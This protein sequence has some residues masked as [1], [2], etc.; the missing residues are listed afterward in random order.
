MSKKVICVLTIIAAL[1][2][3]IGNAK[4]TSKCEITLIEQNRYTIECDEKTE[5]LKLK[6][7]DLIKIKKL[8]KRKVGCDS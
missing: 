2:P 1:L 8:N 4:K 7:G 6:A 3:A 5:S